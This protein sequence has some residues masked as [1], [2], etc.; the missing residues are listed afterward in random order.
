MSAVHTTIRVKDLTTLKPHCGLLG[1]VGGLLG[2]V[3]A[4][5]GLLGLIGVFGVGGVSCRGVSYQAHDVIAS[6][7]AVSLL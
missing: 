6:P 2:P 4:C 3:G 5:W 1:P 7:S